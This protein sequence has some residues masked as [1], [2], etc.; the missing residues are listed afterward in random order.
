MSR[1]SRTARL[2]VGV[3]VALLALVACSDL[4]EPRGGPFEGTIAASAGPGSS[5]A[6]TSQSVEDHILVQADDAPPL[7]TLQAQFWAVAGERQTFKI[8][9]DVPVEQEN[10]S[11]DFFR[12]DL[13]QRSLVA[14]PDGTPLAAGDSVL[15]T[16][17]VDPSRL[18]VELEPTGL[19]FD[20]KE[21]AELR[22]VYLRANADFNGDGV[23]DAADG[24][25][26]TGALGIFF[27]LDA[28]SP[29]E[30]VEADQDLTRKR[31]DADIDH[32]SGYTVSW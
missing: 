5:G 32:F 10:P 15:I 12:L 7:E 11:P 6:P 4:T 24:A 26:E 8:R 3:V 22:L 2:T 23:V 20:P 28:S 25:I 17:T 21:P 16:V 27:R 30:A 18:L 31:F 29:W 1:R 14:L 13:K 19:R 9:Y